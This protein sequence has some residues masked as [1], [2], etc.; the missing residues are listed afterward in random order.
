MERTLRRD[1]YFS[2]EIFRRETEGIFFREWFSAGREEDWP[3][4]GDYQALDV[5][6]ESVLVVRTRDGQLAAHYNVCRHRGSRLVPEGA[7]GSFGGAIRCPYHAWTYALDGALRSAPFLD[8][9]PGFTRSDLTL[10]PVGVA[11]WGGFV[12]V[13]LTP[14]EASS[15]GHDLLGQLGPGPAR[16]QRYPLAHLRSARRIAY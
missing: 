5:L 1:F 15:R 6:G 9:E 4:P 7:R 13:N 3:N 2:E 10:Y 11:S 14:A 12:F 8:E 16:L